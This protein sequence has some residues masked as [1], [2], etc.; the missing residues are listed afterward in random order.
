[1]TRVNISAKHLLAI[2][3][4]I[5]DFSKIEANKLEIECQP[6]ELDTLFANVSNLVVE[7]AAANGL[8]LLIDVAPDVPQHLVGDI[9]RLGQV[10]INFANNAVKF[11]D[12][13]EITLTVRRDSQTTESDGIRLLFT[14]TDTGIGL[15]P[16]QRDQL[17][18]SFHQADASTTRKYGGTGL[19]LS[20]SKRLAE[21][22]GGSIGVDSEPGVGSSFWFTAALKLGEAR[23]DEHAGKLPG[24]LGGRR[25]LIVDDHTGVRQLLQGMLAGLLDES[26]GD[27]CIDTVAS[28]WE[29]LALI[30]GDPD[31]APRYHLVFLDWPMPPPEGAGLAG[32]LQALS[33]YA[34][35]ILMTSHGRDDSRE[36][37]TGIVADSILL[38]PIYRSA[39]IKAILDAFRQ[40]TAAPCPSERDEP[41]SSQAVARLQGIRVLLVDDNEFNRFVAIELLQTAG[42]RVDTAD[43]GLQ[44][45]HRVRETSYDVVLMD[46]QMP[47]MDGVTAAREIRRLPACA[48][49]PIIAMTAN[50]MQAEHDACLAAGMQDVV[51]KPIAPEALWHALNRWVAPPSPP[52][53]GQP[54]LPPSPP[55]PTPTLDREATPLPE[56]T[57]LAT[58]LGLQRTGGRPDRYLKFLDMFVRHQAD[59]PAQLAEALS[60]NDRVTAERLA[61]TCKGSAGTIGATRL[62]AAAEAL[63]TALRNEKPGPDIQPLIAETNAQLD[64]LIAALQAFLAQPRPQAVLP[65]NRTEALTAH[66]KTLLADENTRAIALLA[67]QGD[68]LRTL[69]GREFPV[70]EEAIIEFDFQTAMHSLDKALGTPARPT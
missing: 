18:Q 28:E 2:I 49:L 61:H 17:F 35:V 64:E 67:E 44:A 32:R 6:F 58:E 33:R 65:K 48:A 56:I 43:N 15:T 62:Q 57:G 24:L 66:L 52:S 19:G 50:A 59:F 13:G 54:S 21:L 36:S 23:P 26:I 27:S 10:L 22:M 37:A 53:A 20:I 25:I 63:E 69:L 3:N 46:M 45:L 39:L 55:S 70:F 4:D 68:A 31:K 11:T 9:L 7:R 47:V 12:H 41:G 8:E 29:A 14:V 60:Q 51:T 30:D 5:L 34:K 42:L 1:M 40:P 16:A 38:K